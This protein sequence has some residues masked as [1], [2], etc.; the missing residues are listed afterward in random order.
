[1]SGLPSPPAQRELS[2]LRL[3]GNS[4]HT[5]CAKLLLVALF[6]FLLILVEEAML[7]TLKDLPPEIAPASV[8]KLSPFT[9]T[10]P[11]YL[12]CIL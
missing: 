5:P 10:E 9:N 6:R 7:D 11:P 2:R 1:M 8:P 3:L 12:E 4:W